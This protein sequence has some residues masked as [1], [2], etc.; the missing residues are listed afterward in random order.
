MLTQPARLQLKAALMQTATEVGAPAAQDAH[1]VFQ[2]GA[3]FACAQPFTQVGAF[4][5]VC[6]QPVQLVGARPVAFAVDWDEK[7]ANALLKLASR[8]RFSEA[9]GIKIR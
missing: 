8:A 1:Y 6:I 9:T 7:D 3:P 4:F 5:V 2:P